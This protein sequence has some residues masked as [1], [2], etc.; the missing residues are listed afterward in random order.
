[1][2][3]VLSPTPSSASSA[4]IAERPVAAPPARFTAPPPA[5]PVLQRCGGGTCT[6]GGTCDER[7]IEEDALTPVL[8]AAVQER[9]LQRE[10]QLSQAPAGVIQRYCSRPRLAHLQGLMHSWCDSGISCRGN[11]SCDAINERW[12]A[13][14]RCLQLREQIQ[15]ECYEGNTDAGHA[16]QIATVQ[17]AID[18]C[19]SKW[20]RQRCG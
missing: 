18:F 5:S 10:V 11:M 4:T 9:T 1:M 12:N 2:L 8:R 13:G 6:C 15:D 19:N 3:Q 17:N 7:T 16:E 20:S 14:N